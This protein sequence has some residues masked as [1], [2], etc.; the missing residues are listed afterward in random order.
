MF[1]IIDILYTSKNVG[2]NSII[3]FLCNIVL[4]DQP[5]KIQCARLLSNGYDK[6]VLEVPNT[7]RGQK[8][9]FNTAFINRQPCK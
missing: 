2:S 8:F 4:E 1:N 9:V 6:L 3:P 5:V 7:L